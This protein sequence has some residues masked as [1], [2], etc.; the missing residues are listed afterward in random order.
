[1]QARVERSLRP[2]EISV[3]RLRDYFRHLATDL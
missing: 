1:M 3:E 2:F